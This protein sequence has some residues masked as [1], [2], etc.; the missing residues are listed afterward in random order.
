MHPDWAWGPPSLLYDGC[1]SSFL[2]VKQPGHDIDHPPPSSTED[3]ERVE[4]YLYPRLFLHGL[5]QG[6]IYPYPF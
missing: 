3:K 6:E 2:E 1:W 5:L 4:L